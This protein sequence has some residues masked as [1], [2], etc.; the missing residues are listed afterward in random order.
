MHKRRFV[1]II[2]TRRILGEAG[3]QIFQILPSSLQIGKFP[4]RNA[5]DRVQYFGTGQETG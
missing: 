4:G 2:R 3:E 5:I 1:P